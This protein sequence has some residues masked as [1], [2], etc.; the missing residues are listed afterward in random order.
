MAENK[1]SI[2][3]SDV[4]IEGDLIEK[5][6]IVL[7]AKI[8][9]DIKAEEIETHQKS[10][11]KGNINSNIAALGGLMKGN[12]SSNEIKIK[13]TANIEKGEELMT[14]GIGGVFPFGYRVGIISEIYD[15]A[16]NE[17]LEVKVDFSSDPLVIDFFLVNKE[18]IKDN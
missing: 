13:K 1:T 10:N 4:S 18:K 11:I 8:N 2:L 17:Y 5:D 14:S 3:L 16:D 6:K 15:S 12:I 7:D 9:G